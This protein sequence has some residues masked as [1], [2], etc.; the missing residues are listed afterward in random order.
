MN[1]IGLLSTQEEIEE[2]KNIAKLA[3]LEERIHFLCRMQK[4]KDLLKKE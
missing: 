1:V 2:I 3:T 4:I